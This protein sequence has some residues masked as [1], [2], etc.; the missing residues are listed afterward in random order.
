LGYFG[1]VLQTKMGKNDCHD[2]NMKLKDI[3]AFDNTRMYSFLHICKQ[4]KF[5]S[6]K[7]PSNA[8][9]L[10]IRLNDLNG[11]IIQFLQVWKMAKCGLCFTQSNMKALYNVFWATLGSNKLMVYS[12]TILTMRYAIT[13]S[14][15]YFILCDL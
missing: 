5:M 7:H 1:D 2:V 6:N 15:I 8:I 9:M 12:I 13:N 10:S 3:N 11:K 14:T 4:V